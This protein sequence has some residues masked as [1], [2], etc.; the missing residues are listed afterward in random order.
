MH[1]YIEKECC[2][3]VRVKSALQWELIYSHG[4]T[5]PGSLLLEVGSW[6]EGFHQASL[7]LVIESVDFSLRVR[8]V[9]LVPCSTTGFEL[10]W[11]W[12]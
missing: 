6:R 12:N 11:F 10:V 3:Q 5:T 1:A 9:A 2:R 8:G 4:K 7:G